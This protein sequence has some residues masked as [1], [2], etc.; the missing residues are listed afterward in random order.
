[1]VT[2][3]TAPTLSTA[4]HGVTHDSLS[5]PFH[6]DALAELGDRAH[7][8]VSETQRKVSVTIVE[9]GHL[10]LE[11][12]NVGPAHAYAL[13]IDDDEATRRERSGDVH[14]H[15]GVG[16]RDF[17]RAHQCS[18]PPATIARSVEGRAL[19]MFHIVVSDFEK[20]N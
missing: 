1:L 10:T 20:R 11:E 17:D 2:R 8:L 7:P 5:E 19:M 9:V 14:H 18:C 13:H 16:L 15:T 4:E 6:V 3:S 12:L